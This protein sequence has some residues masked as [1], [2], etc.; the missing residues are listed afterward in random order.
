M[1]T[2][3]ER[4]LLLVASTKLEKGIEGYDNEGTVGDSP[5]D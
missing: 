4:T 3:R 2:D 1:L 5:P